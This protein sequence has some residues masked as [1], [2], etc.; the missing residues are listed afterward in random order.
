MLNFN[1]RYDVIALA[2]LVLCLPA[3]S[4]ASFISSGSTPQLHS[5][6]VVIDGGGVAITTGAV[7]VFPTAAFA[8]TINRVD[9]SADQSG[10]ITVDVW[11]AAGAIP[12]S[13]NKISASAPLT[14]SSAQLA[15][16]GSIS[17]WSTSVAIGDVFGF[18]VVTVATVTR[19][20]GQIWCQ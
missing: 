7:G 9:V 5:I 6:S 3:P 17:G 11:K 15:Q 12:N 1:K 16:N 20:T 19:V 10:S 14:L 4:G 18:T 2:A 8:C 13:G